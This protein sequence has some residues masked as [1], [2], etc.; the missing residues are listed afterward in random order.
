M[1]P[2]RS[3][4][5]L[6]AARVAR[7]MSQ[8]RLSEICDFDRTYPAL[9]ER[10]LRGPTL[11]MLLRLANALGVESVKLVIR[12]IVAGACNTHVSR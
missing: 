5:A 11:A 4:L 12:T 9:L 8:D 10:G 6:R 3:G 7:G 2:A 1:S